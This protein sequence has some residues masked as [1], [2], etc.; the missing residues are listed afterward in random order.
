MNIRV[1]VT[2]GGGNSIEQD[3]PAG[4]TVGEILRNNRIKTYLGYGDNIQASI[5][6]RHVDDT[7]RVGERVEITLETKANQKAADITVEVRFGGGNSVEHRCPQ[8][9]TVGQVLANN[10]V[11]TALGYGDNIVARIDNQEVDNE[12]PVDQGDVISLETRANQK[13]S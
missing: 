12:T 4:T 8:G 9:T 2:F 10:R 13:A 3:F 11:K 5:D 7:Y 6:R 1:K